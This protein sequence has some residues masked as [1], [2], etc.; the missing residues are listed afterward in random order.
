MVAGKNQHVLG[1]L[2][3]DGINILINRVGRAL[4]PLVADPLHGR[5]DFDELAHL[6]AQNV[7]AFADMAV[8]RERLVL[9]EDVNAAQVGV[10]AVGKRDVD[11]AIDAAESDCG[12]GPIAS[13]RIKALPGAACQENPESI[14]HDFPQIPSLCYLPQRNLVFRTADAR[15]KQ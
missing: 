2:G 14:F 7:P 5:Q 11:D 10:Q 4:I 6:A 15:R 3:A 8:E 9:G 1:L 12:L 13:E